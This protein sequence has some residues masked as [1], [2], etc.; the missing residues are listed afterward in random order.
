MYYT[1]V[2]SALIGVLL[3]TGF[4]QSRERMQLKEL[5]GKKNQRG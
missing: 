5:T 2:T 3:L 1:F 4:R